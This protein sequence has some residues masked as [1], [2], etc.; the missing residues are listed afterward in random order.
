MLVVV[1]GEPTCSAAP[2]ML[3]VNVVSDHC[4]HYLQQNK[5]NENIT[6]YVL[7]IV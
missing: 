5:I 1:G 6:S 4:G 7:S 3:V 2:H